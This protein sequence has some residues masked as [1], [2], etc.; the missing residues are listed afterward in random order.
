MK[1]N[2]C[3]IRM[4]RKAGIY[5]YFACR[6]FNFFYLIGSNDLSISYCLS[7]FFLSRAAREDSYGGWSAK[8]MQRAQELLSPEMLQKIRMYH[9]GKIGKGV[10]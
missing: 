5:K 3:K 2:L 10:K 4:T 7:S 1:E 6:Y 8:L 9:Q